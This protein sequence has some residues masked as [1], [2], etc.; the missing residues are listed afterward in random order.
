MLFSNLLNT[1]YN[2]INLSL[3]AKIN[4]PVQTGFYLQASKFQ[5]LPIG[6]VNAVVDKAVFPILSTYKTK[7]EI[8]INYSKF[9]RYITIFV[10]PLIFIISALSS[11][12]I[13]VLLGNRWSES[14]ELLGILIFAGLGSTLQ[15]INRN[16]L[17]S[18]GITK[19]I[20]R[21]DTINI[22]IGLFVLFV[23]ASRG[24]YYVAIGVVIS[25]L[26]G[27]CIQSVL[28]SITIKY[29]LKE[30]MKNISTAVFISVSIF[31]VLKLFLFFIHFTPILEL[32]LGGFI[33][34]IAF[35]IASVIFAKKDVN[36]FVDN[37]KLK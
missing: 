29:S 9:V 34:I 13:I 31:I 30:Q 23:V 11:N 14:G 1:I 7:A 24:V 16:L 17:K 20:L 2:N 10:Y 12:L 5:S 6:I 3:I 33:S 4:S 28:I 37:I 36:L 19:L 15:Y 25:S 21:I 22:L 18:L 27:V 8:L 26:I 32:V 35:I